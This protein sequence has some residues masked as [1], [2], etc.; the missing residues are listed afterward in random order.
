M[1]K[2]VFCHEEEKGFQFKI[3]VK[4]NFPRKNWMVAPP[5][6]EAE[7]EEEKVSGTDL[8]FLSRRQCDQMC[9]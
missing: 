7:Q 6:A 1:R 8:N 5:P 4:K 2:F 3:D 9:F